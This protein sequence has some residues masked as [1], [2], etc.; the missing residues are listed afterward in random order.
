LA[1]F[2]VPKIRFNQCFEKEVERR[3]R[4][5]HYEQK[6]HTDNVRKRAVTKERR[7]R[8]QMLVATIVICNER[9]K[10]WAAHSNDA[11]EQRAK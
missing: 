2:K 10:G 4:R 3:R 8:T 11:G 5:E 6:M 9:L 7:R 1:D